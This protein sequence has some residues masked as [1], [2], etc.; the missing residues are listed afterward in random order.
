[1]HFSE[2]QKMETGCITITF[3]DQGENHRG[4]QKI[5]QAADCGYK[6]S[7]VA[8]IATTL[9]GRGLDVE[10]VDLTTRC[11]PDTVPPPAPASV[12]IVRNGLHSGLGISPDA[13]YSE[14]TALQ[15]DSKALM[16]GRV[17]NKHA[18]H[19]LCFFDT[20]QEPDIE[21]GKGRIVAFDTVPLLKSVK[22][23]LPEMFGEKSRELV[24]E[25]NYYY[26]VSKCGIGFHG[27]TERVKVIAVRLGA[28]MDLHYQ[29]YLR[30]EPIGERFV[31]TLNHGDIYLMSEKAVGGDWKR[32]ILPVLRHA[33][34]C[35]KFV[36]IS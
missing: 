3:G 4:M 16:Y 10:L 1:L 20:A 15:W 25:G 35:P 5:G 27:D 36:T 18:R 14:L 13:L 22:E 29:W 17:V 26:D 30:G 11:P 9:T 21:A 12:L 8:D 31:T 34:G 24:G 7:E 6:F 19:N 28:S 23:R 32:K 2:I 33:A